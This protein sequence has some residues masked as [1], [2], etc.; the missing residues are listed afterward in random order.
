MSKSRVRKYVAQVEADSRIVFVY[1]EMTELPYQFGI[2][3]VLMTPK[4]RIIRGVGK[5]PIMSVSDDTRGRIREF[6]M[7]WCIC[8]KEDAFDF[9]KAVSIAKRRFSKSPLRTQT[10][11]WLNGD[12]CRAIIE[13]EAKYIASHLDKFEGY[14]SNRK[15]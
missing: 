5:K 9:N 3:Q 8:Q 6:N 15:K 4:G 13:N 10:G 11:L 2:A 12:M 1:G 7:G 14:F